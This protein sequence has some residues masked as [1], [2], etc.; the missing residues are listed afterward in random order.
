MRRFGQR[1]VFGQGA[2]RRREFALILQA[3]QQPV[4][5]CQ[6]GVA[7]SA[8]V[9]EGG[10]VGQHGQCGGFGPAEQGRGLAVIAPGGGL[11]PH[12]IAAK[13]RIG[14]IQG[15]DFVFGADPSSS[16]V[17]MKISTI[18]CQ[19][20]R[21]GLSRASRITCMREGA[22]AADHAALACRFSHNARV[23]LTGSTPGCHQNRLSSKAT[24]QVAYF[25]G[26]SAWYGKR[27]WPSVAIRAPSK[28]PRLSSRITDTGL[29]NN[30]RG[31]QKIQKQQQRREYYRRLGVTFYFKYQSLA[32]ERCFFAPANPTLREDRLYVEIQVHLFW[33]FSAG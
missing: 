19:I 4:A 8:G 21:G 16:R 24:T 3:I 14:S 27:H 6:Q 1:L 7:V 32:Q 30:G 29:L 31:K 5:F 12:H 20:V 2:F 25:S 26:I 18:F 10:A 28:S 17:A 15:Q 9:Y 23:R 33:K 13:R 11:Q 22:A